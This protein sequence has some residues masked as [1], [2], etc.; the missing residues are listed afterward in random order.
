M[1]RL[2]TATR[3]LAGSTRTNRF[4]RATSA[5]GTIRNPPT[6]SDPVQNPIVEQNPKFLM[7]VNVLVNNKS[8]LQLMYKPMYKPINAIL[9]FIVMS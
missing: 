2:E 5:T 9:L 4:R 3:R 6:P 7:Y 8:K 1:F